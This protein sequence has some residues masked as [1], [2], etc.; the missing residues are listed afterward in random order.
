MGGREKKIGR[1]KAKREEEFD[2]E[3]GRWWDP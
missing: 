2:R 1:M 3:S